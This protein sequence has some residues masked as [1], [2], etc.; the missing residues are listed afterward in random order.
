MLKEGNLDIHVNLAKLD[1]V[2]RTIWS[3]RTFSC[4]SDS[5]S[6]EHASLCIIGGSTSW[7]SASQVKTVEEVPLIVI[8]C[9]FS[10]NSNGISISNRLKDF[11]QRIYSLASAISQYYSIVLVTHL[12]SSITTP[13]IPEIAQSIPKKKLIP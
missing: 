9:V 4:N 11:C 5:I 6:S 10:R 12:F 13:L 2:L 7:P 8:A 1:V 3:K